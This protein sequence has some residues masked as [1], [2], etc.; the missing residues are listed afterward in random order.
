MSGI[1]DFPPGTLVKQ[2][3]G[4]GGE[5]IG[6]VVDYMDYDAKMTVLPKSPKSSV[7]YFPV[8]ALTTGFVSKTELILSQSK[9]C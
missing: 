9:I 6:V 5:Q 7:V 3:G 2:I 1:D 4:V 8:C